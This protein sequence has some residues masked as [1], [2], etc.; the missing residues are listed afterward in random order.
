MCFDTDSRPPI[1]P[2]AGASVDAQRV[3]LTSE[4][5]TQFAA[6]L[7]RA[8][9]PSGAA[10][11]ILPDVRGLYRFYEE[12]ALRFAETGIDALAIDYFGRTA[13]MNNRGSDFDFMSHV[14]QLTYAGVLQDTSAGIHRLRDVAKPRATFSV[15]FCMGGRLS[16]DLL[17]RR[18]LGLT[19][20]I[21]F[22]GP[23]T[24]THRS[25]SPAPVDVVGDMRG[26]L[27]GLF[28]GSDPGIPPEA[29]TQF[30]MALD[31]A[32]VEHEIVSY[33]NA[34]H[35]FF[36]RKAA[37]FADESADAWQHVVKFIAD[38]TPPA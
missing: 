17:S 2:I 28:G 20:V 4:D 22:Y 19:G 12:L 10:I 13:P 30:D 16:F 21:G 33:P 18:S 11:V 9:K 31:A 8:A 7:A 6:F 3:E 26:A 14:S 1:R 29:V 32:G 27:L 34:P 36:D 5:G 24:G 37:D 35:S 15:G 25:G 23:P 38:Y